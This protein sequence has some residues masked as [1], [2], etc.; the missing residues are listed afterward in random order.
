MPI[1]SSSFAWSGRPPA[2]IANGGLYLRI[3]SSCSLR[4]SFGTKPRMP[5]PQGFLPSLALVSARSWSVSAFR[6]RASEEGQGTAGRDRIR[7]RGRIADAGHRPL[8]D[9]V[10]RAVGDGERR[11]GR[12]VVG[13][14]RRVH[15]PVCG[16]NDVL[17]DSA[18]GHAIRGEG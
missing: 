8:Q 3:P 12:E 6:S 5:T 14:L 1:A 9:R 18:D 7:K 16:F 10:L 17:N 4:I 2:M 13:P 15:Q 11:T